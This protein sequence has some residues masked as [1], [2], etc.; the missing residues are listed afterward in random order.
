MVALKQRFATCP[1]LSGT[2][3]G[4]SSNF[5]I[6]CKCLIVRIQPRTLLDRTYYYY[7]KRTR[8]KCIT[9]PLSKPEK[10]LI[11]YLFILFYFILVCVCFL[12]YTCGSFFVLFV[13][14]V[15]L[16]LQIL[17]HFSHQKVWSMSSPSP[18]CSGPLW[19]LW[20]QSIKEAKTRDLY[21]WAMKNIELL[22]GSLGMLGLKALL[23]GTQ[24]QCWENL[25][26]Q[27]QPSTALSPQPRHQ[28]CK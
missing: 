22:P 11:K 4:L 3:N 14:F 25:W 16:L 9:C 15:S 10:V 18:R 1:P 8:N 19:L 21:S 2:K 23:P 28:T 6:S 7:S 24:P 27:S 5:Q 13:C 26:R 12:M 17:W 20:R